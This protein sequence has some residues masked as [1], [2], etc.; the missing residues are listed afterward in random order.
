MLNRAK[1]PIIID[2]HQDIAYNA[3]AL[4]RDFRTSVLEKRAS[5]ENEERDGI[6][7]VGLPE[8]LS[9]NIRIIFA[10][11]FASPAGEYSLPGHGYSTAAEAEKQA[12]Q[13]LDYYKNL[14]DPRVS[15]VTTSAQLERVL[16]LR[17][18]HV[19][20]VVLMEGA[21]PIVD[22]GDA[23][24]WFDSGV[25]IVG[26]AWHQTRYA[27][28]TGAPGSL[29]EIGRELMRELSGAGFIL[30]TS[31]LAEASF[32]EALGLFDGTVI[33]TH[34]NARTLV[35]TDRQLSDEMIRALIARDG[36]VG[37]VLFNQFLQ[38]E[39]RESGARKDQ[40]TLKTVVDEI[41]FVCDLAGDTRHVAIGTDLDGGFGAE[42]TPR[43][44]DTVA[45]LVK[46]GDALADARYKDDDVENILS[47]NWL[48]I[49]RRALPA[50]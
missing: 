3:I 24:N 37:T 25:R 5:I 42:A 43:E 14:D 35:P 6:P 40:V 11:L 12:R 8:V 39:W 19:G 26:P 46:I 47:G 20:L 15:L 31:H 48:R 38:N 9:G 27:G 7:M 4:G 1:A 49:L 22:P 44:I 30:D 33:A 45:D 16:E 13:Q 34:S 10:T 36:V 21:D 50:V 18:P 29:T 28:G 32:F 23:K 41:T 17:E 2:A